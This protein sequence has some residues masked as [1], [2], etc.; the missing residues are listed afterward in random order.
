MSKTFSQAFSEARKQGLD[1]FQWNGNWYTTKTK[2]ESSAKGTAVTLQARNKDEKYIKGQSQVVNG[3][4]QHS[5]QQ[6]NRYKITKVNGNQFGI[7]DTESYGYIGRAFN[8]LQDAQKFLNSDEFTNMGEAVVA[9]PRTTVDRKSSGYIPVDGRTDLVDKQGNTRVFQNYES[10][11]YFVTDNFGN[12]VGQSYDPAAANPGFMG[13]NVY[14]GSREDMV[15]SELGEKKAEYDR[16]EVNQ[17]ARQKEDRQRAGEEGLIKDI[18]R[19]RENFA[20]GAYNVTMAG[21]NTPTHAVTGLLRTIHPDYSMDDYIKGFYALENPQ[22]TG[23]GTVVSDYMDE[24]LAKNIVQITGDI[25][26]PSFLKLPKRVKGQGFYTHMPTHKLD[27][28]QITMTGD[29]AV[30]LGHATLRNSKGNIV[31]NFGTNLFRNKPVNSSVDLQKISPKLRQQ[32]TLVGLGTKDVSGKFSTLTSRGQVTTTGAN[33][34]AVSPKKLRWRYDTPVIKYNTYRTTFRPGVQNQYIEG[35]TSWTKPQAVFSYRDFAEYSKPESSIQYTVPTAIFEYQNGP[36]NKTV[37]G[38]IQTGDFVPGTTSP[39]W[40]GTIN[41]GSSSMLNTTGIY[42]PGYGGTTAGRAKTNI[43]D[44]YTS[45][46]SPTN[47]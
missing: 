45:N 15:R 14:T 37:L 6:G 26:T 2:E 16:N 13:W 44:K 46:A 47:N 31:G 19:G 12:I 39:H 1:K 17:L 21:L 3:K 32:Q 5:V 34:T 41:G 29:R 9:A 4:A 11:E 7:Y 25:A 8:S 36:S 20:K 30:D 35:L 43:T 23:L 10:G 33:A 40:D 24:G 28:H 18:Q 42:F 27:A 38:R 22:T